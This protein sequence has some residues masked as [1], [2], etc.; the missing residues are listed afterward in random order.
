MKT[1]SCE[2]NRRPID[3]IKSCT[4]MS[5]SIY[6]KRRTARHC[7]PCAKQQRKYVPTRAR[8]RQQ[9]GIWG[10]QACRAFILLAAFSNRKNRN[11]PGNNIQP[12]NRLPAKDS[13][14]FPISSRYNTAFSLHPFYVFRTRTWH[15]GVFLKRR[16]LGFLPVVSL[17]LK[18]WT[19]LSASF[20]FCSIYS[21]QGGQA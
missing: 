4:R 9:T 21:S 1:V 3:F 6:R 17:H 13:P 20:E 18:S 7:Q 19:S 16:C 11:V 12:L 15:L 2:R 10:E 5:S 14:F 8:Q